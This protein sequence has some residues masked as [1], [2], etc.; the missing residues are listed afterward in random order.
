M[1]WW[2]LF[3]PLVNVTE[4]Q[5]GCE[6]DPEAKICN[7]KL[8]FEVGNPDFLCGSPRDREKSYLSKNAHT[9]RQLAQKSKICQ[10]QKCVAVPEV[11]R[12]ELL[13]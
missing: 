3:I 12:K 4:L 5:P 2:N 9:H 13:L 6:K 10:K 8:Y 11:L 1:T 7:Y